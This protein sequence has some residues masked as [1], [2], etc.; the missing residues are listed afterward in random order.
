VKCD[1]RYPVGSHG[2][3]STRQLKDAFEASSTFLKAKTKQSVRPRSSASSRA[4]S[5]CN[6]LTTR[7]AS[8]TLRRSSTLR[9]TRALGLTQPAGAEP[10][11]EPLFRSSRLTNSPAG[12]RPSR[13]WPATP[14]TGSARLQTR[15][16]PRRSEANV[17]KFYPPWP[18]R[19]LL[20]L[21]GLL[22][23]LLLKF[24]HVLHQGARAKRCRT[25]RISEPITRSLPHW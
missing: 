20:V 1:V 21:L 25:K 22:L 15:A 19:L 3:R 17:P 9:A 10:S 7:R 13:R 6:S 23:R 14:A 4:T 11:L 8:G 12:F 24:L 18:L 5:C 2:T 16:I